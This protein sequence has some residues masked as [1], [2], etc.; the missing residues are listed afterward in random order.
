MGNHVTPLVSILTPSFNQAQWLADNLR[1]VAGQTYPAV[2]HVVMD[3]GSA[4]SSV[5]ILRHASPAVRWRSEPDRGQSGAITAIPQSF[6][7]HEIFRERRPIM[8][9][10]SCVEA[11]P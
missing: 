11:H 5:E 6:L 9:N 7:C 8:S 3:G 4:D 10:A 2:E 1:S